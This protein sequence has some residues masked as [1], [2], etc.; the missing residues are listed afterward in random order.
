[1]RSTICKRFLP[2]CGCLFTFS[3]VSSEAR[4]LPLWT[5]P[6]LIALSLAA[7]PAAVHED[8]W[9]NPE[10]QGV[11]SASR[12]KF[13]RLSPWAPRTVIPLEVAGTRGVGRAADFTLP[14]VEIQMSRCRS[15]KRLLSPLSGLGTRVENQLECRE[16]SFLGP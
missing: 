16:G 15:L 14:H 1:M 4:A 9:Q 10:S 12:Y 2:F 13:C 8:L 11:R 6:H 5:R 3:A 7:C